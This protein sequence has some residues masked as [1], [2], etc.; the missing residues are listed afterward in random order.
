[1]GATRPHGERVEK[2][3]LRVNPLS[4]HDL[5]GCCLLDAPDGLVY[6]EIVVGRQ[7]LDG[8]VERLVVKQRI[9][10][11]LPHEPLHGSRGWR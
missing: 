11:L 8:G 2:G 9:G 6:L 7:H 5:P 3:L 4:S 1:M 10:N